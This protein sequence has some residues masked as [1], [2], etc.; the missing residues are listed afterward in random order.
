M[1]EI[2]ALRVRANDLA[3]YSDDNEYNTLISDLFTYAEK[4]TAER[5]RLHE[6]SDGLMTALTMAKTYQ[7]RLRAALTHIQAHDDRV[8]S[9]DWSSRFSQ[10]L[11]I[12]IAALA[13]E[14][15]E[16]IDEPHS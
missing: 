2:E 8:Q 4:V 16:K 6:Q 9:G 14:N 5:D 12:A 10:V 13:T 11:D 15:S 1:S 7:D 3:F